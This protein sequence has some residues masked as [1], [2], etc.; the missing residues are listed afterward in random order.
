[1][2]IR[3]YFVP[4]ALI[5]SLLIAAGCVSFSIDSVSYSNNNLTVYITGSSPANASLQ[6]RVFQVQD[7]GQKEQE[8]TIVP[9]ILEGGRNVIAVP[10]HLGPGTYKLYIYLI[11]NSERQPAVI[12]DIAV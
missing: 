2:D 11:A 6:V 1:M 5:V 10:L 3:S 8:V 7:F 12:R 4:G 9:V